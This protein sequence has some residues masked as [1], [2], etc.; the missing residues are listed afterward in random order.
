MN[1]G[2]N[3]KPNVVIMTSGV[4]KKIEKKDKGE[5]VE[6]NMDG[7]EVSSRTIFHAVV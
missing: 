4:A 3:S 7:L 1:G 6:Q 2:V 5:L